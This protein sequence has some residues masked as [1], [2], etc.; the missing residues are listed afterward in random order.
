MLQIF[1]LAAI[2]KIEARLT[3][4]DISAYGRNESSI[5]FTQLVLVATLEPPLCGTE[6]EA[7]PVLRHSQVGSVE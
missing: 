7:S 4:A 5:R 6:N 2:S 3:E 1:W